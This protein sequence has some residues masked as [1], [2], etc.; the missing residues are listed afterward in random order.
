MLVT[1][2]YFI[3]FPFT[4]AST[5]RKEP[6]REYYTENGCRSRQTL[7]YA[8]CVG[9]CGN[10]CCAA[11]VVRR[12]KVRMVCS[13]NTKYVKNLDI[14]RKC[15][16]TKKCYWLKDAATHTQT[17]DETVVEEDREEKQVVIEDVTKKIKEEGEA[18]VTLNLN[19]NHEYADDSNSYSDLDDIVS[20]EEN[21]NEEPSYDD[22]Y[23]F[24]EEDEEE[25]ETS[26]D[27]Q[28]KI[29]ISEPN[30]DQ[31]HLKD[32]TDDSYEDNDRTTDHDQIRQEKLVR[33]DINFDKIEDKTIKEFLKEKLKYYKTFNTDDD[34]DYDDYD[35]DE[36]ED[37]KMRSNKN[38][39]S[40]SNLDNS[41]AAS[42]GTAGTGGKINNDAGEEETDGKH[43]F[44]SLRKNSNK[45]G[46][47]DAIKIISTPHGK[48]GILYQSGTATDDQKKKDDS[49]SGNSG[50]SSDSKS[51]KI[52][53]VLTA[54]GKVALLY[55]GSSD[56]SNK[57]EP[58]KNL[59]QTDFTEQED[60]K[61]SFINNP[62]NVNI[63][64]EITTSTTTEA[65]T[66]T[67][68]SSTAA[69]GLQNPYGGGT[70]EED[71][72]ILPNI[73]RPLSEVLGI[74]KNQ[75]IQFRITDRVVTATPSLSGIYRK[76][77]PSNHIS[78]I[79]NYE[80]DDGIEEINGNSEYVESTHQHH[81]IVT[82][83]HMIHHQQ[84]DSQMLKPTMSDVL[85]KT[86]V[87]NLAII[88]A[89]ENDIKELE[90]QE[91]TRHQNSHN[92]R[93]HHRHRHR[94]IQDLSA[95]HCAMQAMVGI[96]AMA[97]VFGM[98]GAYFKTRILD[99]FTL[100]HW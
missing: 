84:H 18:T 12:R 59:T 93:K 30:T 74:K 28:E 97:T 44:S 63:V 58:I 64:N 25:T 5:C 50:S 61:T 52:T 77:T 20:D 76:T 14:V 81:H 92:H 91:N 40:L 7:K 48:V 43:L 32:D 6:V 95:I 1:N 33:S 57:Y 62:N 34:D 75:F 100:M 71:N 4:V 72:V 67:V 73:N 49:S 39:N 37:R 26:E 11:K 16:C 78:E 89:F 88:P 60:N 83:P 79:S 65:T 69:K 94:H 82:P 96:A 10:Q 45:L 22:E 46:S 90:Q 29:E 15:G 3:L 98:L 27:Q 9:G 86:E 35:D 53:P 8:K 24:Y 47:N 13:N 56:T 85:T 41:A 42:A 66:T 87:I 80:Y 55:R 17:S 68:A 51:Y 54:D 31:I 19:S 38:T 23:N 99:Q 36:Y 2:Y 21:K 70:N